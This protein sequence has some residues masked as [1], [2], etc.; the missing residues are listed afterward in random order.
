MEKNDL[1]HGADIIVN[2][3]RTSLKAIYQLEVELSNSQDLKY[4]KKRSV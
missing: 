4:P 1:A 2:G 3:L